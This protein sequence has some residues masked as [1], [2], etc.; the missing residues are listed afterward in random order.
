MNPTEDD[1]DRFAK[2]RKEANRPLPFATAEQLFFTPVQSTEQRIKELE[3][4]VKKLEQRLTF[5]QGTN[6]N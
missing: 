4:R 5:A 1:M 2:I 6:F 3:D